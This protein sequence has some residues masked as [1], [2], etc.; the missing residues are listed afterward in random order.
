MDY[1]V[2][3]IDGEPPFIRVERVP[4]TYKFPSGVNLVGVDEWMSLLYRVEYGR[5]KVTVEV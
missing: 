3:E 5:G 2:K 1:Y 4:P